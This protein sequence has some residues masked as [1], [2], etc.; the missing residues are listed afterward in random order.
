MA[1]KRPLFT[2]RRNDATKI[3]DLKEGRYEPVKG[4]E[5]IG[6]FAA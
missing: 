6:S 2:Q 3:T 1:L 4:F 5:Q